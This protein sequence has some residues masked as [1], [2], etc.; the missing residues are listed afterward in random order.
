MCSE[1]P[2]ACPWHSE[3]GFWPQLIL[4]PTSWCGWVVTC[5]QVLSSLA[6]EISKVEPMESCRSGKDCSSVLE[7]FPCCVS[8]QMYFP[9][10][11]LKSHV[12]EKGN[13]LYLGWLL[14]ELELYIKC[15]AQWSAIIDYSYFLPRSSSWATSH[16]H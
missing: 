15:L 2:G 1:H 4:P 13:K 8:L 11:S 14:S 9:S 3:M 10:L 6:K 16:F 7:P 5:H 12:C